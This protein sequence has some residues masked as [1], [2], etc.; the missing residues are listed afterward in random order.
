M[1]AESSF[2]ERSLYDA[3]P[4]YSTENITVLG[5]CLGAPAAGL[6][7]ESLIASGTKRLLL[8]GLSGGIS[9]PDHPIEIGDLIVAEEHAAAAVDQAELALSMVEKLEGAQLSPKFGRVHSVDRPWEETDDLV[10]QSANEGFAALDMEYTALAKIARGRVEFAATFV[11]SDVYRVLGNTV[12]Y[13]RGF[14]SAAVK[15]TT[16]KLCEAIFRNS[17]ANLAHNQ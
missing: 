5:P 4:I 7:A 10:A 1:R 16:A 12:S 2:R 15:N 13:K 17:I 11:V 14:N 3:V 8:V 9:T 6:V